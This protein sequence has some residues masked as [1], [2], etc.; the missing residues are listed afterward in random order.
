MHIK[1]ATIPK[2]I[3]MLI[4]LKQIACMV[5]SICITLG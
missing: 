2:P 5:S 1:T 3:V 4:I